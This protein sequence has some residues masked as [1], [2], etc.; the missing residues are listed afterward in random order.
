MKEEFVMSCIF[1]LCIDCKNYIR[2]DKEDDTNI[3]ICKAFPNGIP[4]EIFWD[5]SDTLSECAN[6][7]RF[8]SLY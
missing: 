5:K 6:G 1:P 7:I 4:D 8:E 3:Y 2:T